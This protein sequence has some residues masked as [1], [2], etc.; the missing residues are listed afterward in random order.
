MELE[1]RQEAIDGERQRAVDKL[2]QCLEGEVRITH[3]YDLAL[4]QA[5]EPEVSRTLLELRGDHGRRAEL[6]RSRIGTF[7]DVAMPAADTAA[8]ESGDDRIAFSG[9]RAAVVTLDRME[10][11]CLRLYATGV[12]LADLSTREFFQTVLLPAQRRTRQLCRA[13]RGGDE[14]GA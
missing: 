1:Q 12:E 7:S 10:R 13:V 9:S 11:R 5:T 8:G 6:L 2:V 3:S 14:D 4:K